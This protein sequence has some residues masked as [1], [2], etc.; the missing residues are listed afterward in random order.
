MKLINLI[1]LFYDIVNKDLTEFISD[2]DDIRSQYQIIGA[3]IRNYYVE[4]Y[5]RDSPM[6]NL[7]IDR[8]KNQLPKK[9]NLK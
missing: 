1:E 9:G 3:L 6:L 4:K 2:N 5:H 7:M 8:I